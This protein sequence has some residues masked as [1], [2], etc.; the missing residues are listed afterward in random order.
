MQKTMHIPVIYLPGVVTKAFHVDWTFDLSLGPR[1][2]PAYGSCPPTTRLVNMR[3]SVDRQEPWVDAPAWTAF[4]RFL[5][6]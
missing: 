5:R 4:S 6:M 1:L 3:S 2:S